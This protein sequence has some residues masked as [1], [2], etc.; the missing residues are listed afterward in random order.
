[1]DHSKLISA[2]EIVR[3]VKNIDP[4]QKSAVT[5]TDAW[6]QDELCSVIQK[7]K[8]FKGFFEILPMFPPTYRYYVGSGHYDLKYVLFVNIYTLSTVNTSLVQAVLK[9]FEDF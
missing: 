7:S 4:L 5:L 8:A 6:A 9:Y 2:A 1:L 3:S